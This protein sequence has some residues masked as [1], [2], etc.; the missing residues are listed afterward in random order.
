[1]PRTVDDAA[2]VI[3]ARARDSTIPFRQSHL[4]PGSSMS[5]PRRCAVLLCFVSLAAAASCDS[6]GPTAPES[7]TTAELNFLHVAAGTPPLAARQ[8][9][10]YAVKGRATGISVYFRAAN[11]STDSLK[12]LDLNVGPNALDRRPDGTTIAP[13]DSVLISLTVT[14]PYH[15]VVDF[16][17]AGLTFA[18]ADR[19]VLRLSWAGCGNDLNYDGRVDANDDAVASQLGIWRQESASLPWFKQ[20]A[21]T[22]KG[23]R[24]VT[25]EIPG[26]TGYALAF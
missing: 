5:I 24:E 18:A 8:A 14:D 23:T 26:F 9:S 12:L 22:S 11:G 15:L 3:D 1:M 16:Q 19:P 25:T 4:M 7:R 21:V 17:P 2:A 10:F 20:D 6:D 13:G